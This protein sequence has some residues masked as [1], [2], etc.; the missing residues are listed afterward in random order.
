MPGV[1]I[2][3][4]GF[5]YNHWRGVFYPEKLAKRSWLEYYAEV[6]ATV[7]LNVTFYRL[8]KEKTFVKWYE[9]TPEG[10]SISLKGSRFITHVKRLKDPE[11]PVRRFM[12]LALLLK[13]KLGV[14][15]WQL[16]P[17]FKKDTERLAV[18]LKA[19]RPYGLRNAFEFRN[20]TWVDMNTFSLIRDEGHALCMADWPPFADDL[21]VTGD[22]VYMRRHGRGGSYDTCYSRNELGKDAGRIRG[23][24]R[25]KKEVFIYFN[26][27]YSGYA[28]RNARELMEL[29]K[30]D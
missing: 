30:P 14:V 11:E 29:L 24:M 19:I 25:K 20:E 8:P 5:L 23:Y 26:N 28:P 2:G 18:F 7:E 3:C 17:N 1:Y 21:P 12:E 6:F 10:F 15:L 9:E 16:P 22:F 27:D 4:S 13:E